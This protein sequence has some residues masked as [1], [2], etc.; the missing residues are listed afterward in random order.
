MP[1]P[2]A[3]TFGLVVWIQS[4]Q[5]ILKLRCICN[6]NGLTMVIPMFWVLNVCKHLFHLFF[7]LPLIK[8][9]IVGDGPVAYCLT[10]SYPSGMALHGTKSDKLNVPAVGK[11]LESTRGIK[12]S[13]TTD[14]FS[15]IGRQRKRYYAQGGQFSTILKRQK[16][17]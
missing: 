7:E 4:H 10:V 8:T 3:V 12:L 15:G 13:P 16:L 2:T 1:Q 11:R 17:S 6:V 9:R 14:T 5:Q